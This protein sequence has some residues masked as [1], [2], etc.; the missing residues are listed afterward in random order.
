MA[1]TDPNELLDDDAMAYYASTIDYMLERQ[2]E[3]NQH[4]ATLREYIAGTP[5]MPWVHRKAESMYSQ[6]LAQAVSN[7]PLLIVDTVWD[8]LAVDGYRL[9]GKDADDVVWK[10]IWQANAMDIYAPQLHREALGTGIGYVSVGEQNG[11]P[12]VRCEVSEEV[13]H[14]ADPENPQRVARVIKTWANLIDGTKQMRYIDDQVVMYWSAP[15]D[16]RAEPT[17]NFMS[18]AWQLDGVLP[19]TRGKVSMVVF[20]ARPSIGGKFLSEI[21]DVLPNFDRINTLTAQTLLAA[22]LGAF[23]I[24]WATG[25]EIPTD[26]NG[27]PVEPFDVALNRL[28]VNSDPE[29]KFGS[30]EGTPLDPYLNAINDAVQQVAA[31]SRTPPFLLSGKVTN[32]SAEALKATE[33]GL[34]QKVYAR[35]ATFGQSWQEVVRLG[36]EVL[37]DSRAEM[38]EMETI[39]RDPENVSDG[40]KVDA[41]MK[42]YS[43]GLPWTAVMER[44]GAT[45]GEINRWSEMRAED[46]FQRMML[47][48]ASS[49]APSLDPGTR[50]GAGEPAAPSQQPAAPSEGATSGDQGQVQG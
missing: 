30:F 9:D 6:L 35:Q 12:V 32:L 8:R 49:G 33:S 20:Y 14:D 15:Y 36:L 45:P 5:M 4:F 18:T 25:M 3:R 13:F 29:G 28:W 7:F 22:E 26:A 38:A 34:V 41:L 43:L 27:D 2:D 23:R 17:P 50:P 11:R 1:L 47:A 39:W 48:S 31:I 46:L 40:Q 16:A 19:N 37:G 24:R 10:D 42:L 44:F 21:D